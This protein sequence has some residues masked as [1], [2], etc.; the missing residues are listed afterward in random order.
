LKSDLTGPGPDTPYTLV[1]IATTIVLEIGPRSGLRIGTRELYMELC[2]TVYE[3]EILTVHEICASGRPDLVRTPTPSSPNQGLF[4]R[5]R[6]AASARQPHRLHDVH[7]GIGSNTREQ[8]T[9]KQED[10]R[11]AHKRSVG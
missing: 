3:Y 7:Q 11:T 10:V 8:Q 2:G 4:Y 6:G 1:G 9:N 5:V